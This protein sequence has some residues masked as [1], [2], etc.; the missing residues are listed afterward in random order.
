MRIALYAGILIALVGMG[1]V[2]A[3]LDWRSSTDQPR[4]EVVEEAATGKERG[5]PVWI[6]GSVIVL[7]FVVALFGLSKR[8]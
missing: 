3:G 2:F 8:N 6:G 1:L 4:T 7:G 5:L